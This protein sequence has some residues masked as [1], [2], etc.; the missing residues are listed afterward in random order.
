MLPHALAAVVLVR[1]TLRFLPPRSWEWMTDHVAAS[2]VPAGKARPS[3]QD[4]AW[5]VRRASSVVPGATCLTQALAAHL[6]L[7]RRG[8]ASRLRIGVARESD[9]K[10]RA[11]AWLESDG[12]IVL[13][14]SSVEAFTVLQSVP[15]AALH[16]GPRD[17]GPRPARRRVGNLYPPSEDT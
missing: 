10:L 1:L 13:G 7:A 14:G 2:R 11:H 5:A 12:I 15:S 6:L 4:V 17:A 3:V 8:Y 16:S 9:E